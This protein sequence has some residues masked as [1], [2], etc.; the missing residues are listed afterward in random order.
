M[1]TRV[2]LYNTIDYAAYEALDHTIAKT[3]VPIG[4]PQR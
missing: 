1:Q 2:E 3:V 4:M